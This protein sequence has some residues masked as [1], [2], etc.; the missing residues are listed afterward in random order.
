MCR[1]KSL[2]LIIPD[3]RFALCI[4]LCLL[5][6]HAQLSRP[7]SARNNKPP[8]HS[9]QQW[10]YGERMIGEKGETAARLRKLNI[11]DLYICTQG[12]K[13]G[14]L[15]LRAIRPSFPTHHAPIYHSV[16]LLPF[17]YNCFPFK[18]LFRGNG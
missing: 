3:F 18:Y 12:K 13:R 6:G 5:S 1:E 15:S 2:V 7:I 14:G 16:F 8:L 4:C 17:N 9:V 11:H 10:G